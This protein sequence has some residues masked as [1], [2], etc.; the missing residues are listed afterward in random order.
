MKLNFM[1]IGL[2]G[3]KFIEIVIALFKFFG[4]IPSNCDDFPLTVKSGT[5]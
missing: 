2:V 3:E 1:V 4:N 5:N